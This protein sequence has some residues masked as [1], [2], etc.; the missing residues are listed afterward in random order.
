MMLIDSEFK[1]LFFKLI[2]Q[3]N[4]KIFFVIIG[5]IETRFYLIVVSTS[6]HAYAVLVSLIAWKKH[7]FI[8]SK[9]KSY[10][11]FLSPANRECWQRL[12][13]F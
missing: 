5:S 1:G 13:R 3:L 6:H 2:W 4:I 11:C 12:N 7:D 8:V 9:F 10:N